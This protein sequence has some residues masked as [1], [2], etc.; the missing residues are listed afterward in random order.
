[1][2]YFYQTKPQKEVFMKKNLTVLKTTIN[3]GLDSPVK[4]LHVTDTHIALDDDGKDCGRKRIF[5]KDFENCSI[6]YF[7]EAVEYAKANG[8]PILH[9]GDFF[10]FLSNNN[11]AFADKYLTPLDYIYA[12]G[13]HDFCHKVGSAKEDYAYKWEHI[14]YSAPHIKNN[15]YF[16][17]RVI[18]GVN[19]VTLDNSYY[20]MTEG[21]IELLRAEAAKGLPI[22]LGVHNPFYNEEQAKKILATGNPCVY[23]VGAPE[24]LLATYPPDRRAQQTPD[25]ATRRAVDYIMNEPM[26]KAI[27]AGHTH[28]N[29]EETL[30]NGIPQITTH[31]SFAGFVR[32]ITL[33]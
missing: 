10:D 3:V 33:L 2:I 21:Q 17:S 24:E 31:G 22:V 20:L 19:I 6:E 28:L 18:G 27:I 16:Y 1:M 23:A 25:E 26:I 5:D 14:K 8:L 30:P 29:L 13:N 32:E 7:F 12:A 9:T 15:L 11:F 4:L